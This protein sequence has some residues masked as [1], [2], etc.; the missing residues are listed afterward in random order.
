METQT[1][2]RLVL[3]LLMTGVVLVFAAR[4]ILWLT[5]LIRSGQPVSDEHGA[6]TT[7]AR[8]S[9]P[10]SKRCSGKPGC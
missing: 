8:A 6:R 2:I 7:S 3:G 5:S 1:L 9:P 4:R 10:R